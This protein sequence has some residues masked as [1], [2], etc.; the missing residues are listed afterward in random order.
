MATIGLTGCGGAEDSK[1]DN[2]NVLPVVFAPDVFELSPISASFFVDVTRQGRVSDGST[3][4]LANLT[5]LTEDTA[6]TPISQTDKG[7]FI[8][9]DYAKVCD[10]RYTL[11]SKTNA[12][13]N[14]SG[15]SRVAIT[16]YSLP[17]ANFPSLSVSTS[18]NVPLTLDVNAL[19]LNAGNNIPSHY[20]LDDYIMVLGSGTAVKG[21]LVNTIVYTPTPDWH[22]VARLLYSYHDSLDSNQLKLGSIAVAVSVDNNTPPIAS[23]FTYPEII[24]SGVTASIDVAPYISDADGDILQLIDVF[25]WNGELAI[26]QVAGDF[27]GRKFT[28]KPT[29]NTSHYITYVVSDH[30]GGYGV[31]MIKINV[32]GPYFDIPVGDDLIFSGPLTLE[33]AQF[34]SIGFVGYVTGNGSNGL[35]GSLT[36]TYTYAMADAYCTAIGARLPTLAEL[37]RLFAQ[38]QSVYS[39]VNKQRWPAGQSYWT[40]TAVTSPNFATFNLDTGIST[41]SYPQARHFLTCVDALPVALEVFG[42]NRIAV[43]TKNTLAVNGVTAGGVRYPYKK[44][45]YWDSANTDQLT[46]SETG[47]V[48]GIA[49]SVPSTVAITVESENGLTASHHILVV[50]SLTDECVDIVDTGSGKLFTNSPSVAYLDNNGGSAANA[51][52]TE[53]GT[54]GPV[55]DFYLFSWN[56]AN[57]LCATY[58]TNSIGGRTNW[59]LA[60]SGELKVEL[61]DGFGNMFIAHGWPTGGYYWSVTPKDSGY[62]AVQLNYGNIRSFNDPSYPRYASCVSEP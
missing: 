62:Y 9:A 22:G 48:T 50:C 42:P 41:D 13:A 3:V 29:S 54:D 33:Q 6:C 53:N 32:G 27:S 38:E 1:T 4:R 58:N 7:F 26:P 37:E 19:L 56:N 20:V 23:D 45:I 43:G 47:I 31:G 11:V 51:T 17:T 25:S 59:R 2:I 40:S 55:G 34:A 57:A 49:V 60:T 10:Y 14:T 46:V 15:I 16:D 12:A 21:E 44:K 30:K 24:A 52:T 28:F 61:F 36:P 18:T 5:L 35:T 8:A 39:G